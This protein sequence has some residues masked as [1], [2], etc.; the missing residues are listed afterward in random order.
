MKHNDATGLNYGAAGWAKMGISA[1][2]E[3]LL[4]PHQHHVAAGGLPLGH[5]H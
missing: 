1:I 5:G 4:L 3:C 2:H